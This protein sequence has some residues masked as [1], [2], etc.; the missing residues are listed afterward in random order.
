MKSRGPRAVSELIVSALPELRERLVEDGVRRTWTAVVGSETARRARPQR[1]TNGVLEIAVDNS[2]W[3][4]ELTL[5]APDLTAK[6]HAQFTGVTSLRFVL[7]ALPAESGKGTPSA[8]RPGRRALDPH[9]T[10]DIETAVAVMEQAIKRDPDSAFLWREMAQWLARVEQPEQALVAAR[11]AV[12]LAP[13]DAGTHL[14]LADLLRAQKKYG[15]A[16]A[17]LERVITLNPS[18]EEPYL[19]LA[20]YY[21]EQKSYERARTVLLRLAERQPKLAQAQFLL[22]RLAVETENWDEAITRLTNAVELD[23]DHDGAWTAL[24]YVY[25]TRHQPEDAIK[26]YRKA[27]QANPDNPGFVE[28]LSDLLIRLGRFNEAQSEEIGRAS[29]RE[30]V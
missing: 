2:P 10:R 17:E 4:H 19:T 14:T 9:E 12:Q 1:L 23:P 13:D 7:T 18:A 25:E 11:K 5:R 22:G 26:V 3:L 6:L 29:C 15:E 27:M 16:E 24:G 21:V 30:R 20:R 28:R 8:E